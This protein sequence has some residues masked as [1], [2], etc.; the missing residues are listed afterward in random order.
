MIY[1][2][3]LIKKFLFDWIDFFV[4]IHKPIIRPNTVL[5]IKLDVAGDYIL[6]RNFFEN[7]RKSPAYKH[8]HITYC[9]NIAIKKLAEYLDSGLIDEFYWIDSRKK[10]L[11][12]ILYRFSVLSKIRK[13][14]FEILLH[15]TR[16]RQF[17][18]E[19]IVKVC[20][21]K[22][23]IGITHYGT[24]QTPAQ[25]IVSDTFYTKLIVLPELYMFELDTLQYFFEQICGQDCQI[26][27]P[28][29]LPENTKTD[30]SIS[31]AYIVVAP[32]AGSKFKEWPLDN[33][34]KLCVHIC[35]TYNIQIMVCGGSADI[36][37]GADI[38]KAHQNII[39][40]CGQTNLPDL[41]YLIN[42][43]TLLI[44][45][46]SGPV[47]IAAA[48]SKPAICFYIANNYF[49]FAPYP[50]NIADQIRYVYPPEIRSQLDDI[51]AMQKYYDGSKINMATI[52]FQSAK[53]AVDAYLKDL[54]VPIL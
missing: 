12:K 35:T 5:I 10:F 24:G 34:K 9:G 31:G 32:W 47:H 4:L 33:Y 17:W 18:T 44:A 48:L 6:V 1:L 19:S 2:R 23:K 37:Q 15:P 11:N 21:A 13:S 43:A 54:N 7:L 30:F 25:T 42:N 39:N 46:E 41:L 27:Y 40:L 52:D 53:Q 3:N 16:T 26:N 50:E 36:Q 14:G 8:T 38:A 22:Q 45:N 28:I 29:R 20:T 51:A 49:R